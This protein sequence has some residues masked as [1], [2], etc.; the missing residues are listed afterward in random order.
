VKG[1]ILRRFEEIG[2]TQ[3]QVVNAPGEFAVDKWDV[4]QGDGNHNKTCQADEE[5]RYSI[6]FSTH[7]RDYTAFPGI[8]Y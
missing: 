5:F 3:A 7:G 6:G 1:N 4:I 8:Y 2:N